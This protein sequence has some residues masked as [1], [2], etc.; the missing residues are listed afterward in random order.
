MIMFWLFSSLAIFFMLAPSFNKD[1]KIS[2][3]IGV[4]PYL[5]TSM[6]PT[7]SLLWIISLMGEFE[8]AFVG[9]NFANLAVTTRAY[10]S[11]NFLMVLAV[12]IFSCVVYAFLIWYLDKVWPWQASGVP[13]HPLFFLKSK[14]MA[15]KPGKPEKSKVPRSDNEEPEPTNVEPIIRMTNVRKE[16]LGGFFTNS[17]KKVAVEHVSLNIYPEQCTVL[18]GHNGAGKTTVF[19]MLVGIIPPTEGE[20]L[21]DGIDVNGALGEQ[22]RGV[23]GVCPQKNIFFPELT[24]SQHLLM[25]SMLRAPHNSWQATR[26]EAKKLLKM[27]HLGKKGNVRTNQLSGGMM[28]KLQLAMA[29]IGNTKVLVLDEPTSGMD[30][31]NRRIIWNVLLKVRRS[32]TILITTHFMEEADALADRI[33]IINA[34]LVQCSGSSMFLKRTF[35]AGYILRISKAKGFNDTEFQKLLKEFAPTAFVYRE[36]ST[37]VA[38]SLSGHK[39]L[40]LVELAQEIEKNGEQLGIDSFGLSYTSLEDVFLKVGAE[41]LNKEGAE[42]QSELTFGEG[43]VQWSPPFV[44]KLIHQQLTGLILKRF[45]FAR[46]YPP[47]FVF[48]LLLPAVIL[49]VAIVVDHSIRSMITHLSA[50]KSS[51]IKFN[52]NL[53]DLYGGDMEVFV[54]GNG[55]GGDLADLTD[56]WKQIHANLYEAKASSLVTPSVNE[57]ALQRAADTNIGY[58]SIGVLYGL[59]V[60]TKKLILWFNSEATHS[61]VLSVINLFEAMLHVILKASTHPQSPYIRIANEP[62]WHEPAGSPKNSQD[63]SATFLAEISDRLI[64]MLGVNLG[65]WALLSLIMLPVALTFLGASYILFPIHEIQSKSKHLQLMTGLPLWLFWLG[66][67]LFDLLVHCVSIAILTLVIVTFDR[68]EA[69]FGDERSKC[70]LCLLLSSCTDVI[71]PSQSYPSP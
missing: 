50:S 71:S 27:L 15:E 3:K 4:W 64:V 59:E 33:V 39:A 41:V 45:H 10:K 47:V 57:W 30:P 46:R 54:K 69:V 20:I 49:A 62:R 63:S 67:L 1:G 17:E 58:Y 25:F 68:D 29:M 11:I 52:L 66:N 70:L 37:E 34:G 53:K 31:E 61:M 38:Y 51:G 6:L 9:L 40:K 22:V 60:A 13:K 7:G 23:V 36:S 12:V 21:I 14:R 55:S 65:L 56:M 32:R 44:N 2:T 24:V 5:A 26:L 42:D 48:Q 35:G 28:R 19:S 16:Y 43:S 18:L 8:K